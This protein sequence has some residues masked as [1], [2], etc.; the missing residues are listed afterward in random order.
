MWS[1]RTNLLN[2]RSIVLVR[3]SP[4]LILMQR[5]SILFGLLGTS[6]VSREAPFE[7]NIVQL[8]LYK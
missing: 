6:F 4:A 3:G 2:V 1:Y 5:I 7:L 8:I